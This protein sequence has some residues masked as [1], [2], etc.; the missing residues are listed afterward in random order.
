MGAGPHNLNATNRSSTAD[1]AQK[2]QQQAESTPKTST[3]EKFHKTTYENV[4][5]GKRT[6]QQNINYK[7]LLGHYA[8]AIR[9]KKEAGESTI[10]PRPLYTVINSGFHW[11]AQ[12]GG[13]SV[14]QKFHETSVEVQNAIKEFEGAAEAPKA[15]PANQ[16]TP[17]EPAKDPGVEPE[18]TPSSPTTGEALTP[19]SVQKNSL[20]FENG[21][22]DVADDLPLPGVPSESG[23]EVGSSSFGSSSPFIIPL[24]SQVL[25]GFSTGNL[26]TPGVT[27]EQG[28]SKVVQNNSSNF[29]NISD[30]G[31]QQSSL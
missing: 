11:L 24:P 7:G 13:E 15:N 4:K 30:N 27:A 6:E 12:N 14:N 16:E 26:L 2:L 22:I 8:N 3:L 28:T 9:E 10:P 20:R 31:I 17:P 5:P 18:P 21:R 1:V 25:P 19:P 29:V 23:N